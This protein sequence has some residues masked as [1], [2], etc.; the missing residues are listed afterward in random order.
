[1]HWSEIGQPSVSAE[2]HQKG[3][4]YVIASGGYHHVMRLIGDNDSVI[5][6]NDDFG[7]F[8]ARFIRNC[9]GINYGTSVAVRRIPMQFGSVFKSN[10]PLVHPFPPQ[11]R[12]DM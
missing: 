3:T 8:H 10:P 9:S 4:V 6:K 7:I 5:L 12:I 2:P 1:M 11:L